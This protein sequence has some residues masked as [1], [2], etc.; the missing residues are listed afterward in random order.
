LYSFFDEIEL[1]HAVNL[2]YKILNVYETHVYGKTSF[3]DPTFKGNEFIR[4]QI[5]MKSLYSA[6]SDYNDKVL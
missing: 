1:I 6:P 2:G 4:R 3:N 5:Y